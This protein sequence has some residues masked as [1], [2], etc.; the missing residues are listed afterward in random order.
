MRDPM[1]RSRHPGGFVV[2]IEFLILMA[3][4]VVPLI[5]GVVV[6]GRKVLTVYLDYKDYREAPYQ[7]A[8]V[9]D[10]SVDPKVVGPVVGYDRFEAPLVIFRESKKKGGVVLGVRPT[11][12]TSYAEV[13]YS[14]PTCTSTPEI[15]KANETSSPMISNDNIPAGFLYQDHHLA[16]A[17]G[18]GN[19]LYVDSLAYASL[20]A[21]GAPAGLLA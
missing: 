3:V 20:S 19:K 9:V 12:V 8:I 14:E 21:P 13:F 5:L 10:S 18:S 6:V 15:R 11:R 2:T 1:F 4:L 17:M 7:Q 16:A